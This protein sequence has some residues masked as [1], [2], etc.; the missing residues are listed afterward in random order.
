MPMHARY[1]DLKTSVDENRIR[2]GFDLENRSG[3][4][5][6]PAQGDSIGWQV[7]D[8]ETS[9]FITEGEW[10]PLPAD[11]PAGARQALETE[12]VLPVQDGPYRVYLSPRSEAAGWSYAGGG[13]FVIIDATLS[14]G[15]CEVKQARVT[16]LGRLRAARLWRS[17]PQL[18]ARPLG[19]IWLNRGL[20]KSMARRDVLA[21]YRGSFGDVLWTVLNPLLLMGTYFFVFGIVL[22]ARFEND[23]S[24]T[25]FALYFL[26]GMLPWLAFSEPVGRSPH[27]VL[28]HRN[29]VKKLVFPLDALPVVQVLSGFLTELFAMAVYI[30]G[31]AILRHSVPASIVWLPL[32]LIPQ[33]L[34]TLGL[35]WFLSALGA[36]ARDLGQIMGFVLTLWFFIT[37][38]CYSE[39]QL[40]RTTPLLKKN[41]IYVLVHGYRSVFL[42][43][44]APD[45]GPLWKM[46][47]LAVIVFLLGHAWFHRLRRTFAD[48]I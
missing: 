5:W 12:I 39:T 19:S 42:E 10:I 34:F 15:R 36:F 24:R 13:P 14:H 41:P 4:R 17:L 33:L 46:W 3:A 37:P 29:F 9:T 30:L 44:H 26:A 16:T 20:I 43:G 8:P 7:Y 31:L 22:Q 21:R 28:E 45:W 47:L 6:S 38:I 1:Y 27:V 25:G 48:V 18:F 40:L 35:C 32:I 2:V 11:M 23:S